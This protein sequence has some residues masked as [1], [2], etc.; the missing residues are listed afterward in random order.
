MGRSQGG[1]T[2]TVHRSIRRIQNK[3]QQVLQL[4]PFI[5]LKQL[6]GILRPWREGNNSPVR[7]CH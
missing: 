1:V 2:N 4:M 7:I 5:E 6:E 3:A